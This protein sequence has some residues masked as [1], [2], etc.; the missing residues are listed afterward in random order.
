MNDQDVVSQILEENNI[1]SGRQLKEIL[2]TAKD[3][4]LAINK[5]QDENGIKMPS[6]EPIIKIL[7]ILNVRRVEFYEAAV[8]DLTERTCAKLRDLGESKSPEA[9]KKLEA[10]LEKCFKMYRLPRIRPIVLETLKQLPTIS[11]DYLDKI[12][13]DDQLYAECAISVR[14]QIWLKHEDLFLVSIEP[15]VQEYLSAKNKLI[16]SVDM[17]PNNFFTCDTVKSRR[18]NP[19]IIELHNITGDRPELF[20]MLNVYLKRKF[21][22]TENIHYCSLRLE[23]SMAARDQNI[24][25]LIKAD[26]AHDLACCMDACLRDKHM[27]AQQTNRLKSILDAKRK[28]PANVIAELAMVAGDSHILHF[29]GTLTMKVLRDMA[30]HMVHLPRDNATLQYLLKML[31]MGLYAREI[32]AEEQPMTA[33]DPDLTTKFL[34]NFVKLIAEDVVRAEIA[35]ASAEV[36]EENL[37]KVNTE[38]SDEIRE[39]VATDRV[40]A[41]LWLHYT[42][43]LFPIKNRI[44]LDMT[45]L[46]RYIDLFAQLADKMTYRD[47][48]VHLIAHRLL[49]SSN[50]D[51]I[52]GDDTFIKHF[53]E[54]YMLHEVEGEQCVKYQVLRLCHILY[55][56]M[57]EVL[58]KAIMEQIHPD[59]LFSN[60]TDATSAEYEQYDLDFRRIASK[61]IPVAPPEEPIVAA[62]FVSPPQV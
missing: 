53:F 21:V 57:G 33:I 19:E 50:L 6:L 26:L 14:Q 49:S 37:P 3:P 7:D 42:W 20:D 34:P 27:D 62:A 25:P 17:S 45:A 4:M 24:E 54:N 60:I 38:V 39:T 51:A 16:N 41:F 58:T 59:R 44:P 35:K 10:Q 55:Q 28:A 52:I 12:V 2:T 48:W 29:I 31:H 1:P 22:E 46:L 13:G 5:F 9:V 30:A 61:I 8:L 47:P 18:Q 32:I 43:N 23:Y 56:P 40:A 15:V 36:R 11:D